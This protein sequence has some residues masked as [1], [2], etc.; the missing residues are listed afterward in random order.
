MAMR[1]GLLRLCGDTFSTICSRAKNLTKIF[2]RC[3]VVITPT[4]RVFAPVRRSVVPSLPTLLS[5]ACCPSPSRPARPTCPTRPIGGSGASPGRCDQCRQARS[6][7]LPCPSR[8]STA[9]PRPSRP[10]RLDARFFKSRQQPSPAYR[11]PCCCPLA[12]PSGVRGLP[13]FVVHSAP[14]CHNHFCH[15]A[16]AAESAAPALQS[17]SP[18]SVRPRSASALAIIRPSPTSVFPTETYRNISPRPICAATYC[19]M[20]PQIQPRPLLSSACC[21]IGGAGSSPGHCPSC[22]SAAMPRSSPPNW[23]R[24]PDTQCQNNAS[25]PAEIMQNVGANPTAPLAVVRLPP[26]KQTASQWLRCPNLQ[27]AP[28]S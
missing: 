23:H 8:S 22:S 10:L 24:V 4:R 5:S 16:T 25:T 7:V 14:R 2:F 11:P 6:L 13:P 15:S 9:T 20:S 26:L 18:N 27:Q 12:V 21:P 3:A 17:C 1:P 19:N 28:A